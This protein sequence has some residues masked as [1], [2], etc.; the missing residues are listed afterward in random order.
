MVELAQAVAVLGP[1]ATPDLLAELLDISAE[2]VTHGINALSASGLL[3]SG[4]FRHE[5]ARQA[6]LEHMT[7]DERAAM[8]GR[9][10]R[11]LY[12]TGA[13]PAILAGHLV[14]ADRV[15]TGWAI[16]VLLEAAERAVADGDA[17]R[18]IAY[19]RRAESE[20]VDDRQRAAIRFELACAE[21]PI[22]PESA[23]RHLSELVADARAGRLDNESVGNLAYYLLWL[24]DTDNAAEI[25]STLDIAQEDAKA[26]KAGFQA[27][28]IR[29]RKS[30]V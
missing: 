20:C 13:A 24:G 27:H 5:A 21:W 3:G 4:Q 10:T 26:Q 22:N 17:N 28:H 19:L 16:P 6:V 8:H 9:A 15:G 23:A 7:A 29:D 18:A 2:S 11:T 30:V 1:S 12:E 25:L 14:D